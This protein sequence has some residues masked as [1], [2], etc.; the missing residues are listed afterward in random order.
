MKMRNGFVS[1]SSSSS[2]IM[3]GVEIEVEPEIREAIEEDSDFNMLTQ[4]SEGTL[5]I[6]KKLMYGVE[7][8]YP[9]AI[10]AP[11]GDEKQ[12]IETT[13]INVCKKHDIEIKPEDF[14]I[15]A[16]NTGY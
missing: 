8:H 15:Y 5:Y 2:F 14:E 11:T 10:K 1:N 13:I 9:T 4:Y 12:Q 7:D 3:Y 6:G 16:G